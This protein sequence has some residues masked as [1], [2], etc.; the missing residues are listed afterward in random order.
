MA[1][2]TRR[3]LSGDNQG[4][5]GSMEPG[6]DLFRDGNP[7]FCLYC[8]F[9]NNGGTPSGDVQGLKIS[10]IPLHVSVEFDTPK[11]GARRR[12]GGKAAIL[13]AMPKAPVH[14]DRSP[15]SRKNQIGLSRKQLV[16]KAVSQ[17]KR[18]KA[19]PQSDLG[20]GISP[21]NP[22]HHPRSSCR[23]DDVDHRRFS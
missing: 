6:T 8:T 14:E 18:M 22:G 21:A 7:A 15:K 9:P 5:L 20:L 19:A 16:M 4:L 23:V 10:H 12:R 3:L 17:T 11:V 2:S 1:K 13:V